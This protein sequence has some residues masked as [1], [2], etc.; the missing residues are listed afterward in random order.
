M[1][2]RSIL[3]GALSAGASITVAFADETPTPTA[4]DDKTEVASVEKVTVTATRQ[5]R[6]TDEVPEFGVDAGQ[7]ERDLLESP[8]ELAYAELG[9]GIAPAQAEELR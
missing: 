2:I 7:T 8:V 9:K 3:L 1:K 5:K 6:R 4:K